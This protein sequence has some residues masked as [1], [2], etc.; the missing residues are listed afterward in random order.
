MRDVMLEIVNKYL[1]MMVTVVELTRVVCCDKSCSLVGFTYDCTKC[2]DKIWKNNPY[3][4]FTETGSTCDSIDLGTQCFKIDKPANLVNSQNINLKDVVIE[5]K[6]FIDVLKIDNY[7]FVFNL[8]KE[9]PLD[10][11]TFSNI[12]VR[13]NIV[14]IIFTFDTEGNLKLVPPTI[15]E[16]VVKKPI[17][18]SDATP[19]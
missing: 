6:D 18:L 17:K 19:V 1:I 11:I 12:V 8:F 3:V 4:S 5:N 2:N 7:F 14:P 15:K 9:Y 13:W 10:K 16:L